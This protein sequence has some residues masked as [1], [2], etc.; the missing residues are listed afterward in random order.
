M[1]TFLFSN[2]Y[3]SNNISYVFNLFIFF[4]LKHFNPISFPT[5]LRV[6]KK[7]GSANITLTFTVLFFFWPI[8]EYINLKQRIIYQHYGLNK[9]HWSEWNK[10]NSPIWLK[11]IV[12]R[13]SKV[14]VTLTGPSVY[15]LFH[16][17]STL[18][19]TLADIQRTYIMEIVKTRI[20][21]YL[22]N[23]RRVRDSTLKPQNY[24]STGHYS[25]HTSIR[26]GFKSSIGSSF[27]LQHIS[28]C[29]GHSRRQT[30]GG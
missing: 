17:V 4:F 14:I 1:F 25:I 30:R 15:Y 26:P 2:R 6:T 5:R 21:A 18:S 7:R 20:C 13:Y 29:D 28:T 11:W 19:A 9:S 8:V 23:W 3:Y 22:L 16:F 27:R 10:L 24:R 12:H